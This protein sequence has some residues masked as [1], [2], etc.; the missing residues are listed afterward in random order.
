MVK[1]LHVATVI[2]SISL[3]ALRGYWRIQGSDR[4][5]QRWVK[6]VPHLNDTILLTTAVILAV[7]MQ[8]YPFVHHWLSAKVI[9]LL[10]Y[11][12]LGMAVIKW[13]PTHQLRWVFYLLALS[14]F[15]YIISVAMTKT[16]LGVFVFL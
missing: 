16:P 7:Q 15:V 5:Q 12:F 13:A 9:A 3:F 2:I 11:I 8:Q 14:T 10:I 6:I 4:M 1:T